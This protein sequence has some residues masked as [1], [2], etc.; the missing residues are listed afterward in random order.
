MGAAA[1]FVTVGT[2]LLA[3]KQASDLGKFNQRV[4]D[5][6]A[7]ILEQEAAQISK[8]K[9]YN[10]T[11][12]NQRFETLQSKTRLGFLKSGVELSGTALKVLQSNAEQAELQRGVI[13]YNAA[14]RERKKLDEANFARISGQIARRRGDLAALGY[15]SQAG[16]SLLNLRQVGII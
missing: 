15:V 13:E 1:P 6:N 10:L 5:R 7:L 3:A 4:S 8:I 2:S 14:Q 16:T 9:E 11:K 12:F